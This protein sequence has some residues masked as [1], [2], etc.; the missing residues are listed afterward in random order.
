MISQSSVI[1]G[2]NIFEY[3]FYFI[4]NII[5]NYHKNYQNI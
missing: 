4:I 3:Q 5:N 2:P 1:Q